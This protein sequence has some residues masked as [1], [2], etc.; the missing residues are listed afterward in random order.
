MKAKNFEKQV[1]LLLFLA[2]Q[3]FLPNFKTFK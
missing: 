2:H 3:L 1:R